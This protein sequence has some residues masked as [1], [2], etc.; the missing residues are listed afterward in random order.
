VV[1][2]IS[3]Q[4]T[5]I[6]IFLLVFS[7]VVFAGNDFN[8]ETFN[9]PPFT[10]FIP[11]ETETAKGLIIFYP[12]GRVEPEAYFWFGEKI[13]EQGYLAAFV[14]F[15]FNLGVLAPNRAR[16]VQRFLLEEGWSWEGDPIIGG[17][18]LGGA[19][20]ARYA[21]N[22]PVGGLFLWAAYPPSWTDL[23]ASQF[24]VLVLMAENDGLATVEDIEKG[25]TQLPQKTRVHL[26]RGGIH[27]FF[28]RYGPQ[29]GDGEPEI[30]REEQEGEIFA[31][32]LE[33]L[34]PDF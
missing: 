31:M 23:T 24:P 27:S 15:P 32:M 33:F 4:V 11:E 22:N 10:L 12:G 34:D 20:A 8:K 14:D 29:R 21:A 3:R 19:M 28:G 25:V 2:L 6:L 16:R 13:A 1:K 30:S 26:I 7:F 9:R 5:F 17:H 18:S